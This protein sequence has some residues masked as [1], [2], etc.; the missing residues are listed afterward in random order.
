MTVTAIT[1]PHS[2]LPRTVLVTGGAGYIGSHACVCLLQAGFEVVVLDNF[3]NSSRDTLERIAHIAVKPV[4]CIE[5]DI[6]DRATLDSL[7]HHHSI[8]AVMHFAG[9]KAVGESCAQPLRYYHNNVQGSLELFA[10]MQRAHVTRLIFSSSATVY[11]L[12]ERVPLTETAALAPCNPYGHTKLAVEQILRD[13]AN[14]TASD[15]T[16]PAWQVAL[17][18]YFNPIGA[19]PSGLIG[20]NPNGIPDNLLPYLT[21]VAIGQREWLPVFGDDY[22]TPDGTGVRDYIHVMDLVEGHVLALKALLDTPTN[23]AGCHTWNLGTGRGHS[24]LDM[25]QQFEQVNGVPIPYRIMPRRPGDISRCWADAS[26]AAQDL[27]WH[28]TRSLRDMLADSWR[29]Q[30]RLSHTAPG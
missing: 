22:D 29:W 26:Q 2:T 24:V 30:Q 8:D 4:A 7:F 25:V 21:Q 1:M 14:A 5:G 10:A 6:R 20:E 13:L 3:C 9:L 18:R 16:H 19:H 15:N 28:A 12:P 23:T 27:G 17:L 11:G